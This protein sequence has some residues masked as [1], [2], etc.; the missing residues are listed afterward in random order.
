[1]DWV[2]A[3]EDL[4][5]LDELG[6]GEDDEDYVPHHGFHDEDEV[7]RPEPPRHETEEKTEDYEGDDEFKYPDEVVQVD[8]DDDDEPIAGDEG[9]SLIHQHESVHMTKKMKEQMKRFRVFYLL[10]SAIVALN[11]IVILLVTVTYMPEF[12]SVYGPTVNIVYER[13]VEMGLEDTGALN[14]V[15][16]VLF[17][18]RSFDT[19]GEAFVLFTAVIGIMLMMQ[20]PKESKDGR[21]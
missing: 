7:D 4:P 14:L 16:A 6:H 21:A 11:V 12:G 3:D 2:N 13:Y 1:M 15:A 10:L 18:Y 8:G 17:S 19:L 20:K 9:A 5:T